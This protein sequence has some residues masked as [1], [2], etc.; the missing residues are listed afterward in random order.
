MRP[1]LQRLPSGR[2]QIWSEPEPSRRYVLGADTAEGRVRDVPA[3]KKRIF[4]P[5]TVG[6]RP[7]YSAIV[8]IDLETAVHVASWHGSCETSEFSA[9]VCAVG[10]HYNRA[11]IV[12]EV[13]NP[14][15][16]IVE[17]L[18]KRFRYPRLYRSKVWNMID[19]D[20]L[21]SSIG[22]RTDD[23]TRQLLISH[24]QEAV[25]S[26]RALTSDKRLCRELRTMV[27]DTM[28]K[29]RACGRDKDDV[30][31]AWALALQGRYE[32]LYGTLAVEGPEH[33]DDRPALDKRAT[34][35]IR[36]L[37]KRSRDANRRSAAGSL[38]HHGVLPLPARAGM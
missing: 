16:V 29:P 18:R 13:N 21:G 22:F 30:I 2:L 25:R 19:R 10:L 20:P 34:A 31:F 23:M 14:G 38:P 35:R 33:K 1:I 3:F 26:G 8:V 27:Y 37:R 5:K 9:I 28:G 15:L 32:S 12:P 4:D 11:L 24:A 7:D 17:N 6:E 36:E